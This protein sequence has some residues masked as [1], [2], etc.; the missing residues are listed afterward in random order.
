MKKKIF[1]QRNEIKIMFK[2][3]SYTINISTVHYGKCTSLLDSLCIRHIYITGCTFMAF[4][5]SFSQ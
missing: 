2:S 5:K 4:I 3:T 1:F